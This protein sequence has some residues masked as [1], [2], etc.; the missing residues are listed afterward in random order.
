MKH[1]HAVNNCTQ[2][3]MAIRPVCH[4]IKSY[5]ASIENGVASPFLVEY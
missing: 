1:R 4:M 5:N 2:A 3:E